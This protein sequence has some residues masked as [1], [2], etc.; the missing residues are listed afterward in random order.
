MRNQWT[1]TNEER[2]GNYIVEEHRASGNYQVTLV[3]DYLR[4]VIAINLSQSEAQETADRLNEQFTC[5]KCS[6][7][8]WECGDNRSE[9]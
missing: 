5:P 6:E 2:R 7:P 4:H 3:L 9:A 1:V 8:V